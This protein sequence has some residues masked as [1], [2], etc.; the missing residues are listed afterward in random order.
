[1]FHAT[2]EAI[3]LAGVSRRTLYSHSDAGLISYRVGPD[4]RRRYD[5]AKLD[6]MYEQLRVTIKVC[7]TLQFE[8]S[9]DWIEVHMYIQCFAL[10]VMPLTLTV[11]TTP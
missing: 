4:G 1:M 2:Q 5:S 9:P 10:S 8:S 7:Q 3:Q 11:T 6:R